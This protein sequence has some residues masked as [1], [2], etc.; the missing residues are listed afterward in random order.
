M[1]AFS[2]SINMA[3]AIAQYLMHHGDLS[4]ISL[5]RKWNF[6]SIDEI[7]LAI[8]FATIASNTFPFLL[9]ILQLLVFKTLYQLWQAIA[10]DC[11]GALLK[12]SKTRLFQESRAG[13]CNDINDVMI[14]PSMLFGYFYLKVLQRSE[15]YASQK[16]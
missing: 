5:D 14:A 12:L 15:P 1:P 3:Y 8:I 4:W 11:F 16:R 2:I 10:I 9:H 6:N 7:N 13:L